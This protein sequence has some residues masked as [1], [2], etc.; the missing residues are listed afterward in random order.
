MSRRDEWDYEDDGERARGRATQRDYL[1]KYR[2]KIYDYD[3]EDIS[4]EEYFSEDSPI[5]DDEDEE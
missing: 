1:N 4:A 3:D 2:H 5:L